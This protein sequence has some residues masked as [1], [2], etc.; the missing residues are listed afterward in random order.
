[1]IQT[2]VWRFSW[3]RLLKMKATLSWRDSGGIGI[4]SSFSVATRRVSM[5]VA[6]AMEGCKMTGYYS[7]LLWQVMSW[8]S[9]SQSQNEFHW[10]QTTARTQHKWIYT[11]PRWNHISCGSF[12]YSHSCSCCSGSWSHRF[13]RCG[14]SWQAPRK[15]LALR[16][17][18]WLFG[19]QT[20]I[21]VLWTN[22]SVDDKERAFHNA[23]LKQEPSN[24]R[25]NGH[26]MIAPIWRSSA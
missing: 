4:F 15:D 8:E 14:Y 3:L 23:S 5:F 16:A 26:S 6:L 1:M 22:K 11:Y 24:R 9:R 17:I 20:I 25:N 18:R 19:L 12:G 2:L 7:R 13:V 10:A 21:D